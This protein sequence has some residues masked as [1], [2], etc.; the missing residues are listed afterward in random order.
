MQNNPPCVYILKPP[1]VS[2]VMFN[3]TPYPLLP[4]PI[5]TPYATSSQHLS[6]IQK[7]LPRLPSPALLLLWT[8]RS[9]VPL[10][11][12]QIAHELPPR[13]QLHPLPHPLLPRRPFNL[14]AFK[15]ITSSCI[16]RATNSQPTTLNQALPLLSY[17]WLC[18]IL[19]K[20]I[21]H[22]TTSRTRM[23]ESCRILTLPPR[24]V[25]LLSIET[26]AWR[27]YII[28]IFHALGPTSSP[29]SMFLILPFNAGYCLTCTRSH[30]FRYTVAP[31]LMIWSSPEI[32]DQLRPRLIC[33]KPDVSRFHRIDVI[34]PKNCMS[35]VDISCNLRLVD[36][37]RAHFHE[38][39]VRQ[40]YHDAANSLSF[41]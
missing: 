27:Q 28:S 37:R 30:I 35:H 14:T 11:V 26:S 31:L 7:I 5:S 38:Y 20:S 22:G 4:P 23:G 2:T 36:A 18:S 41:C 13:R 21:L 19:I 9:V 25:R 15:C 40:H 39:H 1:L 24:C 33:L 10:A 16:D 3:L 32:W 29:P 12:S 6:R 17:A 8:F 34:T